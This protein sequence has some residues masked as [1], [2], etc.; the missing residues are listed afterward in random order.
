[1]TVMKNS[2]IILIIILCLLL[3]PFVILSQSK[4]ITII[5]KT[6]ILPANGVV[7][8]TGDTDELGFWNIMHKMNK[9][10]K[11]EWQFDVTAERGD[12]I[13][14]KFTRGDW[15]TEAVDSNGVEYP[16]FSLLVKND[17]TLI[18][19]LSNWRDL[20]QKKIVI[21][22]E[23]I[24]N[25]CGFLE[26]FEGWKYRV[27]DDTLWA[28]PSFDDSEWEM[29]NPQLNREDFDKLDWTGNIWFRNHIYIDSTFWNIPF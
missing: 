5:A 23:R 12:T 2:S 3:A 10:S 25:K 19:K 11:N 21:T 4:K 9:V 28:D 16:N 26:L 15:T 6:E 7:H 1:M 20:V 13:Q 29:I 8:I 18:Y 22:E 17:T 24:K 27:G 14:F